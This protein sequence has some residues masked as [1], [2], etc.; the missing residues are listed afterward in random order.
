MCWYIK[1]RMM[2]SRM[3]FYNG[4]WWSIVWCWSWT[5]M[6]WYNS[7]SSV[8]NWSRGS[9]AHDFMAIMVHMHKVE[10]ESTVRMMVQV[11]YR[12]WMM[13]HMGW[14]MDHWSQSGM[15]QWGSRMD[16]LKN[17]FFN[18]RSSINNGSDRMRQ[19]MVVVRWSMV[20]NFSFMMNW[21]KSWSKGLSWFMCGSKYYWMFRNQFGSK[22]NRLRFNRN[23]WN[24]RNK[25]NSWDWAWSRCSR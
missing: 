9:L 23:N 7:W 24:H 22:G 17:H 14:V 4:R 16:W 10:V 2:W 20:K 19:R 3:L 13:S 25:W 6:N 8:M 11:A 15:D 5:G 18:W 1:N 21:S 12:F